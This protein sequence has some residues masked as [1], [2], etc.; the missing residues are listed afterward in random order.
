MLHFCSVADITNILAVADRY[1]DEI[2]GVR[3]ATTIKLNRFIRRNL[4]YAD[5]VTEYFDV[6]K[7]GYGQSFNVWL[8]K[9]GITAVEVGYSTYRGWS[10]NILT[11]DERYTLD[12]ARGRLTV[13]GLLRPWQQGLRVVY[14]GGFPSK[15]DPDQELMDCPEELRFAATQ[16]AIFDA[17]R[18]LGLDQGTATDDDKKTPVRMTGDLLSDVASAFL[19]YRR[20]LGN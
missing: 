17:R 19:D 5:T 15:A 18:Y 10:D 11:V 9:K 6:P 14:S 7:V 13:F 12:A 3:N 1:T 4:E 20:P 8:E 2:A 16:Q